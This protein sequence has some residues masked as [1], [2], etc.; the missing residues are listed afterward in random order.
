MT[1][2]IKQELSKLE[3]LHRIKILY[4]VESGSRAWGFASTDSDWDVRFIYVHHPDWYLSIETHKDNIEFI[5]PNDIDLSGWELKKTLNLFRKS[6]PPLLE[7]LRSPIVYKQQFDTASWMREAGTQFFSAKSCMYHYLH[8]AQ[9]NL[10]A[11]F[12]TDEVRL[13][14]Y[15][16]VLRPILACS[17]I[18][19]TGEMAPMEFDTLLNFEPLSVELRKAIDELLERKKSGDELKTGSRIAV[20]DTFIEEKIAHLRSYLQQYPAESQ[21]DIELLNS[22][23]RNTLKQAW[24]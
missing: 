15:F 3:E 18:E 5:L 20:I 2:E 17:W 11:Y 7:W 16:Y 14:K 23:F 22:I 10:E 9:G 1:E 21:L 12:K 8:M 6:N 24:N 13:K 4:A 19:R